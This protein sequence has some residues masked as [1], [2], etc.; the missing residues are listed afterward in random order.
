[1]LKK[2]A[3]RVPI[4]EELFSFTEFDQLPA[5]AKPFS[6]IFSDTLKLV[7]VKSEVRRLATSETEPQVVLFFEVLQKPTQDYHLF[8]YLLD[9]T[10][11]ITGATDYPQPAIFWWPTSRWETGDRRQ[12]RVNTIP[13]WTGDKTE[14]GY[15]LGLSGNNDPWDTSA[16]LPITLTGESNSQP[17]DDGALLPIAAFRRFGGL[18]YPVSLEIIQQ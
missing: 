10:G 8:V 14:F 6:V 11:T 15:A 5:E 4:P 18:V 2:G 17:I 9:Q 12:V 1:L 7:G 3:E 13:W 16:R